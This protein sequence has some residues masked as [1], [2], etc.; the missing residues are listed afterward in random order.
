MPAFSRTLA[1]FALAAVFAVATPV[2]RDN[3]VNCA[4]STTNGV[5]QVTE[6]NVASF[7][8]NA[9]FM[10]L[11]PTFNAVWADC[12]KKQGF[13]GETI[14]QEGTGFRES[15]PNQQAAA[16]VQPESQLSQPLKEVQ[17]T[18]NT[19]IK[20]IVADTNPATTNKKNSETLAVNLGDNAVKKI[21]DPKSLPV[22]STE[23][24]I[25]TLA[26]KPVSNDPSNQRTQ[27]SSSN[28]PTSIEE[29]ISPNNQQTTAKTQKTT[30]N[31]SAQPPVVNLP[32]NLG[33]DLNKAVSEVKPVEQQL[34]KAITHAESCD[35]K[36][37]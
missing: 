37:P 10:S 27:G 23:Q 7:Q 11:N 16:K 4:I 22:A 2:P 18:D 28:P 30:V 29:T 32:L 33:T 5:V 19:A 15:T 17:A 9:Q 6:K 21:E 13:M 20:Q 35:C 1:V 24:K 25:T 8:S 12:C 26:E 31:E 34:E 14:Q 3:L 36:K